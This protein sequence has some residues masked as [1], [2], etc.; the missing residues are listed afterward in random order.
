MSDNKKINAPKTVSENA[1]KGLALRRQYGR[2]GT[3]VGI[4]RARDLKNQRNLSER[5]I[6]KMVSYFARHEVDKKAENFGN[7]EKPSAGYIAWLL[8]GGDEGWEWAKEV[9]NTFYNQDT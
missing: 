4:A 9:K 3:R 2:G 7:D 5:T 1:K 8:W 6:K